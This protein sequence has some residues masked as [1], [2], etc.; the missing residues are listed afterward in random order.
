[1]KNVHFKP[2]ISASRRYKGSPTAWVSETFV[3]GW[4]TKT[5]RQT[6]LQST[7]PAQ[8]MIFLQQFLRGVLNVRVTPN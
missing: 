3:V 1:M 7:Q 8:R 4:V 6:A 2:E 5:T